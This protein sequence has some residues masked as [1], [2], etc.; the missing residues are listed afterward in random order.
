MIDFDNEEVRWWMREIEYIVGVMQ[1]SWEEVTVDNV[2]RELHDLYEGTDY[3]P[4]DLPEMCDYYL[5]RYSDPFDG[6][7][8][9]PSDLKFLTE[10][11]KSALLKAV[12]AKSNLLKAQAAELDAYINTV[13]GESTN[14][15]EPQR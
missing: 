12:T 2:V 13:F 6:L 10:S 14:E 5:Q 1:P 8:A 7:G 9:V 11:G 4:D 15:I 3:V